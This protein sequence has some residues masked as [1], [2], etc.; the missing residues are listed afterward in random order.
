MAFWAQ[1][2]SATR[3]T[4]ETGRMKLVDVAEFYTLTGGGVRTYIDQKMAIGASL[5]HDV[6]V[7]APGSEYRVE[8]RPG[9]RVIWVPA[10]TL[11]ADKNYRLFWNFS[12]IHAII[13]AEQPDVVEASSPWTAAWIVAA[14]QGDAAKAHFLHSDPVA[15]YPYR[16]FAGLLEE[17]TIDRI[18]FWFWAQLRALDRRFDRMIVSGTWLQQRMMRYGIR[19]PAVA[20]L[21][22]DVSAFD[23]ALRD[24][25]LRR[26]MLARCGMPEDA[27]LFIGM[28]RHHPEKRWPSIMRATV[29][30]GLARPIGL[31]LI[32]DGVARN[33]V[34]RAA[35]KHTHVHVAGRIDER[36]LIARMLASADGLIHGS[37][38]ETFGL[39]VAEAL[40]SGLPLVVPD[41]GG[42]VEL[43]RPEYAEF[44][45]SGDRKGAR[46]AVIRFQARDWAAMSA[47]AAAA[48][49]KIGTAREHFVRLFQIYADLARDHRARRSRARAQPIVTPEPSFPQEATYRPA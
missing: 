21:G 22:V 1:A 12:Q 15:A 29:P 17:G 9:G 10:Q 33:D 27:M 49:A 20:P 43:G 31:F 41:T 4:N 44:Y 38:S 37:G 48:G 34:E 47:A 25:A 6:V 7:I 35:A 26:D 24:L 42:C 39:A 36:G 40:A 32:G 14:W 30:H 13:D 45:R 11:I 5:G 2:P 28:G 23:P 16:W 46:A 3:W 8:Q 19:R 18:F